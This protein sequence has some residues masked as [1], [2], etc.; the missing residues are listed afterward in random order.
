ML[1]HLSIGL[2]YGKIIPSMGIKLPSDNQ[3]RA[4]NQ[5]GRLNPWWITGF[6]D[7]EGCFSISIFKNKT[8]KLGLQVFPEFVVTQGAKSLSVLEALQQYFDC[9]K[10]YINNRSDNHREPLYRYCVRSSKDIKQKIIPFFEKH[11]L[12]TAKHK[13]FLV[14]CQVVNAIEVRE[15]LSLEGLERIRTLAATTNRRK[16]RI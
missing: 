15:H 13:D 3:I 8:S 12:Q 5:Q 16:V 11:P 7:G 1:E 14:F 2:Y 4:D 6:V 9:G 10:L